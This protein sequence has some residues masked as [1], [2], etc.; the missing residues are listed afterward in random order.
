MIPTIAL[1]IN[2]AMAQA[3]PG[4]PVPTL[5]CQNQTGDSFKFVKIGNPRNQSHAHVEEIKGSNLFGGVW[6]W[7]TVDEPGFAVSREVYRTS[8]GTLTFSYQK[9]VSRGGFCGR[10]ECPP[11]NS[12]YLTTA[13]VETTTGQKVV[14]TCE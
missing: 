2:L 5:N 13:K 6:L 9:L 3:Y 7:K 11:Q 14:Y 4:G 12:K 8:L 1:L 10:G